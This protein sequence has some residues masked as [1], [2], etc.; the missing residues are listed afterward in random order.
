[1]KPHFEQS[2]YVIPDEE[3]D[4]DE[5]ED[6]Q[7]SQCSSQDSLQHARSGS[8][9]FLAHFTDVIMDIS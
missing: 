2:E 7:W 8:E 9:S 6:G 3:E 1:L 5:D 4:D